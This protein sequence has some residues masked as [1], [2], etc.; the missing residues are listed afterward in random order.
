MIHKSREHRVTATAQNPWFLRGSVCV[1]LSLMCLFACLLVL[2]L[3]TISF[4]CFHH[5]FSS[6]FRPSHTVDSFSRGFFSPTAPHPVTENRHPAEQYRLFLFLIRIFAPFRLLFFVVPFSLNKI[7]QWMGFSGTCRAA[8]NT[9]YTNEK[10]RRCFTSTHE[11]Y[12]VFRTEDTIRNG[13]EVPKIGATCC[14]F[15]THIVLSKKKKNERQRTKEKE[16]TTYH[17]DWRSPGIT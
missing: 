11:K 10:Y 13:E 14:P 4:S 3:L 15:F 5:I 9:T 2:S 1:S 8:D 7:I 16:K 12:G 17:C 6:S